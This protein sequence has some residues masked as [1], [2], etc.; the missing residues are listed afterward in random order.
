MKE[1][2]CLNKGEMLKQIIYLDRNNTPDIWTD[3]SS[4]IK[5]AS[6]RSEIHDFKTILIVP[7]Q[8]SF[9]FSLYK[10]MNPITPPFIYECIK[11][12]FG[13][14]S[15]DCLSSADKPKVVEVILKFAKLYDGVDFNNKQHLLKN[16]DYF[17]N[18]EFMRFNERLPL[19]TEV[20][21]GIVEGYNMTPPDFQPPSNE[22]IEKV[23]QLVDMQIQTDLK[24]QESQTMHTKKEFT[25]EE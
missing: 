12:I 13:R 17:L 10:T 4:T 18:L 11:R 21:N 24:N 20:F 3:I 7:Q 5:Q 9:D 22:T 19:E 1:N 2:T 15:H 6:E 8:P 25:G 16:F 14:K 23:I